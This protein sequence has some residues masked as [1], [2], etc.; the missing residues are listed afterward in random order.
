VKVLVTGATGFLGSHIVDQL[1]ARGD[2]VRALAR[3]TSDISYLAARDVEVVTGDVTDVASLSSAV[4]GVEVVY[5]AAAKV[6]DWGP[7]SE[8]RSG[9]IDGTRNVLRA[10][11]EAGAP[12]FLHVSTDGV[13]A[14][15]AFRERVTEDSP[16]ERRFGWLD[17][18]RRAKQAAEAKARRYAAAGPLAVTIVRPGLLLGERDAAVLP[19]AIAFLQSGAAM[20]LGTGYNRLPY[21]YVGDVASA[22]ILAAT[23]ETAAGRVYNVVSD[24]VVTQ[25]DLFQTIAVATGLQAPRRGLPRRATY[26]IAFA[27]E[28]W[29]VLRGRRSRPAMTRFGVNLLALD[30]A[31]DASK[32]RRE[33]GWAP[34]VAMSE[35]VRRSVEWS[36]ER[37][38]GQVGG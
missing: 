17:Y 14:L 26:M 12:R 9:T 33:V 30:Y 11:A 31:E 23:S 4:R 15:S 6:S 2:G 19:G 24:E 1:L 20:Y 13:Y 18:Y 35:A 16:L 10:A 29:C 3:P 25:R 38:S 28:A 8:F 21:V 7:W 36:R 27:M 22:C 5:H 34:N 32:L 37:R